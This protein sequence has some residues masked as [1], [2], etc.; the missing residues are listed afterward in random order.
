MAVESADD[1]AIFF[2]ADDFGVTAT[3]TPSGGGALSVNGIFDNEYFETDA[4]G[5]VAFA[6][7]QPMFHCRTAD[8]PSAAEGDSLTVSG[9]GYV[10][11]NVRPDGTGMT[12]LI[13][14][15]N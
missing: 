5:E 9:V 4:G 3:Y 10:V 12:M 8:V 7:Q 1:R 11:R 14:E 15:E 2:S 6:L 13:L